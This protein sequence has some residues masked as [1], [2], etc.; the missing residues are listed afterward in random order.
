[1]NLA[2]KCVAEMFK[3]APKVAVE[4]RYQRLR[5]ALELLSKSP[6]R[7]IPD[8]PNA[9]QCDGCFAR[10]VIAEDDSL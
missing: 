4:T 10:I 9:E 2:E 8:G 1:M 6:C 5:I 7:C 3:P